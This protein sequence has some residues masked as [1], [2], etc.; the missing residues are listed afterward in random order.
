LRGFSGT[1]EHNRT[2][3]GQFHGQGVELGTAKRQLQ[4]AVQ[5]CSQ[6]LLLAVRRETLGMSLLAV[7]VRL[8]PRTSGFSWFVPNHLAMLSPQ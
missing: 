4:L 1:T 8:Q 6:G 7:R 2:E 5:P 3:A